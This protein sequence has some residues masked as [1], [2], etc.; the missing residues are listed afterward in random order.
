MY[1]LGITGGIASGKSVVADY[2]A[3]Y[4]ITIVD[5]D[6][7]A[8]IVVE[9]G[10]PAL[11]KIAAHFGSHLIGSNAKLDRAGLR[12]I[13]FENDAER[14]WVEELLHP[15]INDEIVMQ[16]AAAESAYAILVSP[17]L[18]ES[19]Q[20]NLVDR[21]LLVEASEQL[22]ISRAMTRDTARE[23]Q[24]KAILASQMSPE[25]RRSLADDIIN[26]ESDLDSLKKQVH[27]LHTKYLNL[28]KS[29][30]D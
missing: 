12:K 21:I 2:F 10:T 15:L 1:T 24:I 5:A 28:A 18:L 7:A 19:N 9:P 4:G 27:A 20:T 8:R 30:D 26:N 25:E 11:K 23:A 16:L 17:L 13:V 3:E 29:H 14:K 6:I 22:Q